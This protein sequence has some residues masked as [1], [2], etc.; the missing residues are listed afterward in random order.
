MYVPHCIIFYHMRVIFQRSLNLNELLNS[1]SFTFLSTSLIE[2]PL[3]THPFL[4]L[5]RIAPYLLILARLVLLRVAGIVHRFLFE[6]KTLLLV[7]L[8][9]LSFRSQVVPQRP[10]NRQERFTQLVLLIQLPDL[11]DQ[12]LLLHVVDRLLKEQ[13]IFHSSS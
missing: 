8:L 1:R 7:Q 9:I 4:P 5:R 13:A 6:T 12:L 2:C 10:L 11:T 3:P